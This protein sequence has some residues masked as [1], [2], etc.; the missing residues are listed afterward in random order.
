METT[1]TKDE[2]IQKVITELRATNKALKIGGAMGL[3]DMD[4]QFIGV[5]SC[6]LKQPERKLPVLNAKVGK[7]IPKELPTF[8]RR[9]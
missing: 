5:I 2:V 4:F 3:T 9:T 8:E 7:S 1:Y 6:A